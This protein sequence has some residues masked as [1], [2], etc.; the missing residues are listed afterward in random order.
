MM[1]PNKIRW[2]LINKL[3]S[4]KEKSCIRDGLFPYPDPIPLGETAVEIRQFRRDLGYKFKSN[5]PHWKDEMM[6]EIAKKEILKI[7]NYA[8]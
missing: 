8:K 4:N 5:S 3:L 2:W 6:G 1:L 7:K